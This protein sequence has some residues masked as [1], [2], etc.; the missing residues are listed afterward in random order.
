VDGRTIAISV[1][2]NTHS[3]SLSAADC[4]CFDAG[5]CRMSVLNTT[6]GIIIIIIIII[7]K[8]GPSPSTD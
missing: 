7:I 1:S 8:V 4:C 2:E 6:S 5:Y 3:F